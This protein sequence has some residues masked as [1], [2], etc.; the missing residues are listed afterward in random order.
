MNVTTS[1]QEYLKF[2]LFIRP[3]EL[4]DPPLTVVTE[5][6]SFASINYG[7]EWWSPGIGLVRAVQT[8]TAAYHDTNYQLQTGSMTWTR[9]LKAYHFN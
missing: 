5:A 3:L 8:G 1:D 6:G 2:K 4:S 7:N 9:T